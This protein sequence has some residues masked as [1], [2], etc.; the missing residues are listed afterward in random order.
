MEPQSINF[1]SA[2]HSP[3]RRTNSPEN[4]PAPDPG[5]KLEKIPLT[6]LEHSQGVETHEFGNDSGQNG[7]K[8][9]L[10]VSDLPQIVPVTPIA[11]ASD[12]SV[13]DTAAVNNDDVIEK[14]WVIETKKVLKE[15]VGDPHAKK[16]EISKL[17]AQYTKDTTGKQLKIPEDT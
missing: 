1:N 16:H 6:G 8:T 11:P 15:T 4:L 13:V 14:R 7:P 3:D 12:V 17:T 9:T 5:R 10:P 2:P